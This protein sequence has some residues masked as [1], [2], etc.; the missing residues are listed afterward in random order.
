MNSDQPRLILVQGPTAVGKTARAIELAR[1]LH[2]EILS[3]D[4]RQ[5]YSELDIGV[6][7]PSEQELSMAKHHFIACRSVEHPYN[8]YDFSRDALALLQELF[9]THPVVVAV[10][11]SGLYADALTYGVA[12]MPDPSP[13]L[14]ASLQQQPLESLQRQLQ[15]LDPDYYAKV[16]L[17]N[18]VRIQRALEV[19]ITT[20]QP[21]S[22]VLQQRMPPRPFS[23]TREIVSAE[24][25]VLR[26]RINT[27]VDAMVAQGLLQ[28]VESQLPHRHLNT[29]NT[30]GYRELF[31]IVS[32]EQPMSSLPA[33][34][35]QIKLNTWHYA[36]KQQ[37]WLR[38]Y[39]VNE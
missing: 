32:G 7:R 17:N 1:E 23:F 29:L 39:R 25:S 13:E 31:P 5:F 10:G 22:Q 28:E 4:S 35:E 15:D 11:G 37:T 24:P 8:I 33:A 2:T 34:I 21:Y 27:R 38:K 20:R 9:K 6:A 18:K 36:K 30:V 16:D 26:D 3:F 12:L 19:T 14:R